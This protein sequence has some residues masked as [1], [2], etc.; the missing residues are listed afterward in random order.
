MKF[1]ISASDADI[2]ENS[3]ISY[4]LSNDTDFAINMTTGTLRSR[5]SFDF[6]QEMSFD[7]EIIAVDNGNF[8]RMDTAQLIINITDINDNAPF[9][10]NLPNSLDFPENI[11]VGTPIMNVM[12]D[13]FDSGNNAMV[14][15]IQHTTFLYCTH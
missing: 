4:F 15:K 9:F 10:L 3:R 11:S 8:S 6:E 5:R 7:L 1:Q 14:K 2:G 13:D 12:A